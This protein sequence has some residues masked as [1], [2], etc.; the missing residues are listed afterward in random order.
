MRTSILRLDA[1]AKVTG[2]ARYAA[3][4]QFPGMVHVKVLY[5][6]HPHARIRRIA[7]S[8]ARGIP[9][10]LAVLTARDLPGIPG[11]ERER[12]VLALDRVRYLGEGVA[13]TVA[14]DE[15]TAREALARIMVEYDVLPAV[16][17]PEEALKAEAPELHP[18]GNKLCHFKVRHGDPEAGFAAAEVIL[19][20]TYRTHRVYHAALEPEAAVAVPGA[21]GT[22]TIYCPTK[23][24]FN[25]RRIVA[26]ALA[27]DLNQVRVV[28]TTIGGSFGGKD[29]DMAVVAARAALAA[30]VTGRPA[31][32]VMTR[33]ESLKESTK[34][35]PYVLHYKVGARRDGT[36]VAMKIH[37][38]TDAGAY[39]SKTPLVAWRSTVEAAGPYVIPHVH[40]DIVAAFTN[41]MPSDALRGFGSPQVNLA[42]ELLMDELAGELGLDP[43]ELR[44]KNGYREGSEAVTGQSLRDV[45]LTECLT[46]VAAATGWQGKRQAY[47]RQ[48]GPRR[49]GIGLACSF[50]GSCFGAG[51]EGLDAAGAMLNVER[52]GSINVS[53]GICEVG[54]G[55]RSAFARIIAELLGVEAA[56][57]HVSPVDSA[58]VVDSGPTVASRGTVVGGHAARLA[59]EQVRRAMA[60]VAAAILNVPEDDLEFAG[61]AVYSRKDPERRLS[62]REL[63]GA[64]YSRGVSLYGFG[65]YKIPDLHWDGEKGQGEAYFSYVYAAA[66]AEVEVD[67]ETG[68]VEIINYTAAHDVGNA[69]NPDAVAGQIAG[70]GAMGIG[71][72]LME[73]AE[74]CQGKLVNTNFATYLI[75]TT[76]DTGRITPLII[77][78]PD[79]LGPLGARGLG[80]PATQIV[81][82]A[83]INAICQATGRR[84]YELPATLERVW[85][86]VRERGEE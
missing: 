31:R 20:R 30:L 13:I 34:R 37:G 64:C 82:P 23:S 61:E 75:P 39:A 68:Q 62:F 12:P 77:E 4:L 42:V 79:P 54:Q 73:S 84:L 24:P 45:S 83:I 18:G 58:R 55:S 43:L 67:L 76:L 60:G 52:D 9:G 11:R 6:T 65:W 33:E 44:L 27:L 36:L 3:D 59:A 46:K 66:V 10:V 28:E 50:R 53:T 63:A 41:N 7:T 51:G 69:L 25:L 40:T 15:V 16:F 72:A 26:E 70:G 81:A 80:E 1:L 32:L 86:A 38:I 74:P 49:R 48:E 17:D 85:R 8:Q 56:R 47:A 2:R 71:Y 35:H 22:V 21:D 14:E 19:E 57:I 78:H 29:Y 5:S